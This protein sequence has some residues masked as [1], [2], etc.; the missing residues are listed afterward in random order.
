ME[1]TNFDDTSPST[2][3]TTC[4]LLR[5]PDELLDDIFCLVYAQEHVYDVN[6]PWPA[7]LHSPL[8]RRLYRVQQPSL[9]RIVLI[10]RY[11]DLRSLRDTVRDVPGVGNNVAELVL[12]TEHEEW[13][14]E[15]RAR[16]QAQHERGAAEQGDGENTNDDGEVVQLVA[17]VDPAQSDPAH[18]HGLLEHLPCLEILRCT[19]LDGRL[20]ALLLADDRVPRLLERLWHL[21]IVAKKVVPEVR[22]STVGWAAQLARF[23]ALASLEITQLEPGNVFPPVASPVPVLAALKILKLSCEGFGA[24][25]G[26]P[27]GELAPNLDE[28]WLSECQYTAAVDFSPVL[29]A[30]PVG[31]RRIHIDVP[32]SKVVRSVNYVDAIL[33]RF[34]HLVDLTLCPGTFSLRGLFGALRHM[35]YLEILSFAPH[36]PVCDVLLA[37]LVTGPSR[38]PS[39]NCLILDHVYCAKGPSVDRTS[40]QPFPPQDGSDTPKF[41]MKQG[42]VAPRWPRGGSEAHLAAVVERART[43]GIE[44]IGIALK[45]IGWQVNFE[46]EK[47]S[48]LLLWGERTGDYVE[49]RRELGHEVVDKHIEGVKAAAAA[50]ATRLT[51]FPTP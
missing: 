42:W 50:A 39:L 29:R 23:D 32:F 25:T 17:P 11:R 13:L 26:P 34:R 43:S 15:D 27:L 7:P 2:S 21:E 3:S 40:P 35:P 24:W 37:L 16:Q 20:L 6:S 49:A 14:D 1:N 45:C 9:Y 12:C 36:A 5:L 8:S 4:H 38:P 44:V 28:L 48:A 31:L 51:G 18:L 46:R 47:R 41:R 19:H 30:S 10:E 33:P 22:A